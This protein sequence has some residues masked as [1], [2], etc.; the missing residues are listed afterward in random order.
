MHIC[1]LLRCR[2]ERE[3]RMRIRRLGHMYTYKCKELRLAQMRMYALQNFKGFRIYLIGC[4]LHMIRMSEHAN[5][6]KKEKIYIYC[7]AILL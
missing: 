5:G 2:N 3:V 7:T 6:M 1:N 4:E